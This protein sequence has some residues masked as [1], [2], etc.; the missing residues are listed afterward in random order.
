MYQEGRRT[1][2]AFQSLVYFFLR[3]WASGICVCYR[4]KFLAPFIPPELRVREEMPR[5]WRT[6]AALP[7]L[8][9]SHP[10]PSWEC[11]MRACIPRQILRV[12]LAKTKCDSKLSLLFTFSL[13]E[14]LFKRESVSHRDFRLTQLTLSQLCCAWVCGGGGDGGGKN[15]T[16]DPEHARCLL[17]SPHAFAEQTQHRN[18]NEWWC[19]VSTVYLQWQQETPLLLGWNP[20]NTFSATKGTSWSHQFLWCEVW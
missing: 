18:K 4:H 13:N 6:V 1:R 20:G 16:Q 3:D 10:P 12:P 8:P 7:N 17:Y 11:T 5:N 2:A 15:R 14:N 19:M 9:S